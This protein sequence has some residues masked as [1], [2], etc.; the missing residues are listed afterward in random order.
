[1]GSP[2]SQKVTLTRVNDA[3]SPNSFSVL[4]CGGCVLPLPTLPVL[5]LGCDGADV[6]LHHALTFNG[7]RAASLY[8]ILL[9]FSCGGLGAAATR[10]FVPVLDVSYS[11]GFVEC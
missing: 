1:M 5:V 10:D 8:R 9:V 3:A 4:G 6:A 11:F 2:Q 7:S